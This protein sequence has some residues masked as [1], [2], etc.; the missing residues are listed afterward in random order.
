MS[1]QASCES[2]SA[3]LLGDLALSDLTFELVSFR[4]SLKQALGKYTLTLQFLRPN[5]V[6]TPIS[7]FAAIFGKDITV[8][9]TERR[10]TWTL[11]S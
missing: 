8:S 2:S 6:Q 9:M 7:V 1:I 11:I 10:R 4:K 3:T 5:A